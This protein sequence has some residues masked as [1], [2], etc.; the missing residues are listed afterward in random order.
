MRG[1]KAQMLESCETLS[2]SNLTVREKVA[3]SAI[4]QRP[5]LLLAEG[6]TFIDFLRSYNDNAQAVFSRLWAVNASNNFVSA[7]KGHFDVGTH[8]GGGIGWIGELRLD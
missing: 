8:C 1:E 5:L 4:G 3:A 2:I 7:S 6:T